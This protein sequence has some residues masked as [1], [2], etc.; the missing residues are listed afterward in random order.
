MT[1]DQLPENFDGYFQL[2]QGVYGV[3]LTDLMNAEYGNFD[4][5]R[6]PPAQPEVADGVSGSPAFQ[7]PR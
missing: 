1:S 6:R 7:I 2:E 5:S 4:I 3:I